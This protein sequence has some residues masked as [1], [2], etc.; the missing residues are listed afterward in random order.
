MI[1]NPKGLKNIP[2]IR[3]YVAMFLRNI[4]L[5]V[6]TIHLF[7][8]KVYE[9]EKNQILFHKYFVG[10]NILYIF[11]EIIKKSI[12]MKNTILTLI[13]TLI[14]LVVNSQVI[15]VKMNGYYNYQH[16]S[17]ISLYDAEKEGKL[18]LISLC[19]TT[20]TYI[21]DLSSSK[22]KVINPDSTVWEGNITEI[23]PTGNVFDVYVGDCLIILSNDVNT[24]EFVYIMEWK[25]EFFIDCELSFGNQLDVTIQK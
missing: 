24:G 10:M 22:M 14:S 25:K 15:T 23:V 7:G 2:A 13:V 11:V 9:F 4:C 5:Q 21:F 18:E 8:F 20:T 3:Q 17:N 19:K 16:P 12:T 1:S 6:I